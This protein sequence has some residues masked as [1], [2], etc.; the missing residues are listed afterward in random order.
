MKRQDVH[1]AEPCHADWQE[2]DGD[3][4]RRFCDA[5]SKHVHFISGMTRDEAQAL[6]DERA[7]EH[8][9]VRYLSQ[10]DELLFR[11]DPAPERRLFWQR[12]GVNRLV[13]AAALALPLSLAAACD[14]PTSPVESTADAPIVIQDG[15][16]PKL[17][18][19]PTQPH[20]STAPITQP[21][22]GR[23]PTFQATPPADP[24]EP[25][26]TLGNR[27]RRVPTPK[28]GEHEEGS[29]CAEKVEQP[30][31]V[32]HVMG[33]M[34]AR[35]KRPIKILP[36]EEEKVADPGPKR[37]KTS[38]KPHAEE[39]IHMQETTGDIKLD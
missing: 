22:A 2:M 30:K 12:D 25:V 19:S 36:R 14:S 5:C 6:L 20:T 29:D 37:A 39:G 27:A 23:A 16:A 26:L 28:D 11:D 34:P 17:N 9:C 10:D 33:R 32:H 18:T 21:G 15:K 8:L 24:P 1:I 3:S 7:D 31:V 38:A 4:E 35:K 13:A